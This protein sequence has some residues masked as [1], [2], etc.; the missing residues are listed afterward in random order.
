MSMACPF[1][2]L[3][4]QANQIAIPVI[5]KAELM[6]GAYKSQKKAENKGLLIT[7]KYHSPSQGGRPDPGHR[8]PVLPGG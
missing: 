7:M 5:V 3:R 8:G 1:R 4:A 6:Q 2:L